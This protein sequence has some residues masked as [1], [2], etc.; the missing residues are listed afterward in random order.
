MGRN[1]TFRSVHQRPDLISYFGGKHPPAFFPGP[2]ATRSPHVRISV[3][4]FV[5][6]FWHGAQRITD[7]VGGAFQNGELGA[8]TKKF[9][10]HADIVLLMPGHAWRYTPNKADATT[11]R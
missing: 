8:V 11:L 10:I 4:G 9:V 7:Q 1:R 3:H 2:N 6:A 5:N